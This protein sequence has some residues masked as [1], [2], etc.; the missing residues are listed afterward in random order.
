[1]GLPGL[2]YLVR[3]ADEVREAPAGEFLS[4][5]CS[6]PGVPLSESE[7]TGEELVGG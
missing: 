5:G 6:H 1:M 3:V 4:L 2:G 7:S